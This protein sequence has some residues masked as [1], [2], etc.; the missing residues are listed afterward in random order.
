MSCTIEK[1]NVIIFLFIDLCAYR[2]F[3]PN[4]NSEIIFQI[5][6]SIQLKDFDKLDSFGICLLPKVGIPIHKTAI[7]LFKKKS[8]I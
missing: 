3:T 1:P 4:N 8:I 2:K 6:F 7:F 5:S